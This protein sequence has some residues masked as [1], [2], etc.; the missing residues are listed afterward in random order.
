MLKIKQ[1]PTLLFMNKDQLLNVTL[2]KVKIDAIIHSLTADV[3]ITQTFRNDKSTSIDAVYYFPV[4][5]QADYAFT[6]YIDI[7]EKLLLYQ[8]KL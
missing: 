6:V 4:K 3:T 2:E 1:D 8:E 7:V 5:I